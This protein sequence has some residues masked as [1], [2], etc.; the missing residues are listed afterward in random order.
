MY[1][2]HLRN[3][4]GK[5][6][7]EIADEF[8]RRD[9]KAANILAPVEKQCEWLHNIGLRNILI[10]VKVLEFFIWRKETVKP[11]WTCVVSY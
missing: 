7:Q 10:V 4:A 9:D 3:D 1:N 6:R 8:Y 5:T 2:M 11:Y